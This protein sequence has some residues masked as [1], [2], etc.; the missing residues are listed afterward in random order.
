MHCPEA[1]DGMVLLTVTN[2]VNPFV[3]MSWH[4]AAAQVREEV[5]VGEEEEE[6]EEEA[7]RLLESWDKYRSK[8]ASSS[9][10][11]RSG[12]IVRKI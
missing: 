3:C 12:T 4:V 2:I 8:E 1:Q 11:M 6:E 7:E 9:C 10:S 5:E